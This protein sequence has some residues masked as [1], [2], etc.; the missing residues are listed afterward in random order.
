MDQGMTLANARKFN[1]HENVFPDGAAEYVR[2][3]PYGT[4]VTG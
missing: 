2:S 1:A 4:P 3:T